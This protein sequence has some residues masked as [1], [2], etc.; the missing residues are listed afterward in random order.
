MDYFC[1]SSNNEKG[2]VPKKQDF[3]TEVQDHEHNLIIDLEAISD[4]LL[5][6]FVL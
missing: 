1:R 5:C 4:P 3:D 6:M 2:V